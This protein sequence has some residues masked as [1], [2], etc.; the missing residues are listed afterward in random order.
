MTEVLKALP[1]LSVQDVLAMRR[2]NENEAARKSF[3]VFVEQA[4]DVLE[5]GTKFVPGLHVDAICEHLQAVIEDRIRDLII[6]VPPGHAK[7]LLTCVFWPAWAWIDRPGLRFLFGSYRAE[8]ATRDSVKCRTLIQ[9]P[10][11]QERW[12]D[13]FKL[14]TDQNQKQRFEN[15]K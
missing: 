12:G 11:Y 10:F 9:S 1:P 6:N 14:K 13:R 3:R 15:D 8:L 4:W 2:H 7:S 5:P